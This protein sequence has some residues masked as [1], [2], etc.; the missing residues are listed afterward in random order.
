MY[1]EKK[2][3]QAKDIKAVA[4]E[5]IK[6]NICQSE[7]FFSPSKSALSSFFFN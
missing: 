4:N 2:N 6:R 7:Y 5:V 3:T 1:L